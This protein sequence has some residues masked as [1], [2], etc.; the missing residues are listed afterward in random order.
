MKRARILLITV[1]TILSCNRY[2]KPLNDEGE[3]GRF[4]IQSDLLLLHYD[5]KT[6]VDDLHSIAAFASLVRIPQFSKVNYHAVAGSYGVQ[7]GEYVPPNILFK[8]AFDNKWSDAHSNFEKA[9]DEVF[10][11]SLE[12]LEKKEGDIWIAEAGQSDFSS[13]LI[14]KIKEQKINLDTKERIHIVQHSNWNEETTKKENLDYVKLN[15]DYHKIPD[16]NSANNGTPCFNSKV[17]LNWKMIV[18]D[19]ELRKLWSL[20]TSLANKYNGKDGRYNNESIKS[21]GLDFS[22]FSEVQW[23]FNIENIDSCSEYLNFIQANK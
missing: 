11:K 2:T 3:F 14:A 7:E 5:C 21:G 4:K 8:E 16:G 15:G 10:T 22:D 23:I 19:D 1:V 18:K 20:A 17:A 12:T 9:L 6:D 13:H